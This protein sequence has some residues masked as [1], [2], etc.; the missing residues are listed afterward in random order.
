[1]P[2]SVGEPFQ[3]LAEAGWVGT[4]PKGLRFGA[5]AVARF[6]VEERLEI[7]KEIILV[8]RCWLVLDIIGSVMVH[9]VEIVASLDKRFFFGRELGK[10]VAEL[11][12]HGVGVVAE[13]NRVC[14]PGDSKFDLSIA[15]FDVFWIIGVPGICSIAYSG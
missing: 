7:A 10:P 4:K 5:D 2:I 9:T 8:G 15:C 11:L 3:E 1:M 12:T 14:E 13:V 6:A